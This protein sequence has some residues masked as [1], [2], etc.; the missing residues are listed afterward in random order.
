[1]IFSEDIDIAFH[2]AHRQR[3]LQ[4]VNNCA[5]FR[6]VNWLI[7]QQTYKSLMFIKQPAIPLFS[8]C[9]ITMKSL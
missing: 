3:H 5:R 4:N 8:K 7:L 9:S 1:M 2:Q 6:L